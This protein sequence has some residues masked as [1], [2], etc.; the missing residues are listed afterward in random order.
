MKIR[1]IT[2][3]A[4]TKIHA[5]LPPTINAII[6]EKMSINGALTTILIAIANEF[7]ALV[8]SVVIL[9]TKLEAWKWS[10]FSNENDST[11]AYKSLLK[12]LAKPEEA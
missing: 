4:M 3:I 9:V 10:I 1:P 11:F 8:T 7:C 6:A 2:G 5:I 12:F